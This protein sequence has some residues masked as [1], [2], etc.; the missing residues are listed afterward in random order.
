[1][2]EAFS[3]EL[4]LFFSKQVITPG[5]VV[6][7]Q[8]SY[9][10]EFKATPINRG[11][12]GDNA[13]INLLNDKGVA[14]PIIL[15]GHSGETTFTEYRKIKIDNS[16]FTTRENTYQIANNIYS[17]LKGN[18]VYNFTLPSVFYLT[19][20]NEKVAKVELKYEGV[21]VD[22]LTFKCST[23]TEENSYE[24]QFDITILKKTY[25]NVTVDGRIEP[26]TGIDIKRTYS[27]EDIINTGKVW[28]EVQ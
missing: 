1:M 21:N 6:S 27:L 3:Q 28:L 16:I 26:H 17:T 11:T 5:D 23:E 9:D 2:A 25:E 4:K 8:A 15:S 24:I 13:V 10:G 7:V 22:G 18:P 20:N 12:Y 14:T 19:T